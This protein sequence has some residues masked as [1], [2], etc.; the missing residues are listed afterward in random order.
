MA[1]KRG[2]RGVA[3]AASVCGDSDTAVPRSV[4]VTTAPALG[5]GSC[6]QSRRLGDRRSGGGAGLRRPAAAARASAAVRF[7]PV[8]VLSGRAIEER[9]GSRPRVCTPERR[10]D[11]DPLTHGASS[12]SPGRARRSVVL[13]DGGRPARAAAC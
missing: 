7:P 3:R 6:C 9:L 4:R 13:L 5:G 1:R 2:S 11:S 12:A 10:T 8:R